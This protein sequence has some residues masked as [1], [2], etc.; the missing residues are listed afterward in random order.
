MKFIITILLSILIQ[1]VYAITKQDIGNATQNRVHFIV[2]HL[3]PQNAKDKRMLTLSCAQVPSV[4]H[5]S[6][7]TTD[8][9]F[10]DSVNE[11][12][13]DFNITATKV[14]LRIKYTINGLVG[15]AYMGFI[16]DYL[17]HSGDTVELF[18]DKDSFHFGGK[19][20]KLLNLQSEIF[21]LQRPQIPELSR[22][23]SAYFKTVDRAFKASLDKQIQFIEKHK[24]ALNENFYRYLKNQ[25]IG[26]WH[27]MSVKQILG[28]AII[29]T[30]FGT[31][32]IKYYRNN[33][34][35]VAIPK[36]KDLDESSNFIDFLYHKERLDYEA[37]HP[38]KN[39]EKKG[40][41]II[42][43]N[44]ATKYTG[45]IRDRLLVVAFVHLSKSYLDVSDYFSKHQNLIPPS[46]P[47]FEVYTKIKRAFDPGKPAYNFALPDSTGKIVKLSDFKGK[48]V[49]IDFWFT[50]CL[51]CKYLTAAMAPVLK[52][53]NKKDLVM[54]TVSV[55]KN[56]GLWIESLKSG[57]YTHPGSVNLLALGG[58][59]PILKN[60]N[61][62]AYPRLM[63]IDKDGK[64]ASVKLPT[65]HTPE[66]K[67]ELIAT[68][69][70]AIDR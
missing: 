33:P 17:I 70:K 67:A 42:M 9:V 48:V 64:V 38:S 16:Q 43:D 21:E 52:N 44:I 13:F 39:P 6:Y 12:A 15:K 56:K 55:N 69:D 66:G 22:E 35:R 30:A 37:I 53:F 2:H 49:L 24:A 63:L 10:S 31:R 5:I 3:D 57:E 62:T 50:G 11:R 59:D 41:E 19:T 4:A 7:N 34:L 25:A 45:R 61:V 20:A 65:P 27:F 58:N 47:Y 23:S 46:S 54:L 60:F 8:T 51:P 68:I 32:A 14:G 40:G 18:L 1:D 26:Y 29:D 28:A 36:D